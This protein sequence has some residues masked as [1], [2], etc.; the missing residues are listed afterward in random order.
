M[1]GATGVFTNLVKIQAFL[2]ANVITQNGLLLAGLAFMVVGFGFKI[3][4]APFHMW[5]PDVYE[6][7]PTPV[8]AFMA[9]GVKAAGFAGLL[10]CSSPPSG[11]PTSTS[12]AR[13]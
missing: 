10:R 3:A 4:G 9:V 11:P 1:Y 5:T 2:S 6:G 13:C 7:A 12:G 8:V